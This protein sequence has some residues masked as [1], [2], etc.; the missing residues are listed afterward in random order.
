[1]V[2]KDYVEQCRLVPRQQQLKELKDSSLETLIEKFGDEGAARPVFEALRASRQGYVRI[3][4]VLPSRGPEES[5]WTYALAEGLPLH[6]DTPE[7]W[8]STSNVVSIDWET[9][10]FR[11]RNSVY[12]FSLDVDM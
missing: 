2:D 7:S 6:L 1:M 5:G 11:T 12:T 9:G 3:R 10:T 4:R 8:Y